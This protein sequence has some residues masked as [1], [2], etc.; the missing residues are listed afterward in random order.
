M[1]VVFC[2]LILSACAPRVSRRVPAAAIAELPLERKLTLLDAENSLL[3]ANDAR[4]AQEEKIAQAAEA[5]RASRRRVR[6]AEDARDRDKDKGRELGDAAVREAE[7]RR[8][9][10]DKDRALQ[11]ALL[12]QAEAELMVADAR[13]EQA[14]ASE[15]E[16]AA[17]AGAGGVH[18]ADYAAQVTKLEKVRDERAGDA[19]KVRAEVD[20][21]RTEWDSSREQL[22]KLSGGAQG[23]VWV[24]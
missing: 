3:A 8:D 9:V 23:S 15:V 4:D 18:V 14:R 7:R 12:R 11:R 16:A 24:Q 1:A 17:L 5:Y 22:A 10:C 21:L 2:A 13:F 19:Q 20:A 6:E